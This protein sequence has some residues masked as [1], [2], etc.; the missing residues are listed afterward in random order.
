MPKR[1]IYVWQLARVLGAE[2][3]VNNVV[4]KALRAKISAVWIKVADGSSPYANVTG[5]M[6]SQ[7]AALVKRARAKGLEVWG[8]QV[9]HCVNTAAAKAEADLFSDIADKYLL[10]GLIMDAEGTSVYFRGGVEEARVYGGEMRKTADRFDKPLAISSND[11][12]G[13]IEGWSLKFS[14]IAAV[15]D[16]NFPQTYYGASVSVAN[17]IDRAAAANSGVP[18]PFVPVGAGF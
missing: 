14:E 15:A 16:L 10:D 9:P 2:G 1:Y 8:W 7:M 17:R 13:N 3:G 18:A 4:D 6:A 12:P 5:Q 11:I